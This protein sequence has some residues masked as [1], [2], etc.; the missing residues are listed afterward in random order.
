MA[1]PFA[2]TYAKPAGS[3]PFSIVL[4]AENGTGLDRVVTDACHGLAKEG[5]LAVA[6][7]LFA[8]DPPDGT[9]LRRLDAAAA[10]AAQ[11]G[12]DMARL[13]IVG[14]GPGGRAAWIYDA[15]SPTFSKP[16]SPGTAPCRAKRLRPIR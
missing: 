11:H 7:A 15:Y 9:L 8:G 16:R 10:W 2:G 13:G 6:P 12:G 4:V 1:V 5:F 3:G 14:F